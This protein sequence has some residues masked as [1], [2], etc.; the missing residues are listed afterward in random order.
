MGTRARLAVVSLLRE[1]DREAKL[2]PA[3]TGERVLVC[4][5]KVRLGDDCQK[6]PGTFTDATEPANAERIVNKASRLFYR[7][8][9]SEPDN[10]KL[11]VGGVARDATN[12]EVW[13]SAGEYELIAEKDGKKHVGKIKFD[14][15][16]QGAGVQVP[17]SVKRYRRPALACG[18]RACLVTALSP[19]R[20]AAWRGQ[21]P[22]RSAEHEAPRAG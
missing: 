17:A 8:V 19:R 14:K 22:P 9:V 6:Q 10:A 2:T 5:A 15:G 20:L 12:T 13:E 16:N 1:K 7:P 11:V 3:Q 18:R 4:W 21:G